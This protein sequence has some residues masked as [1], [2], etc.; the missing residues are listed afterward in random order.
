M[1]ISVVILAGGGTFHNSKE[2]DFPT[3]LIELDGVPLIQRIIKD[4][5]EF[6]SLKVIVVVNQNEVEKFHIE[7]TLHIIDPNIVVVG[8]TPTATGGAASSALLALQKVDPHS[9]VLFLNGNE[10]LDVDYK[11]L[12]DNFRAEE[13]DAGIVGFDSV[14]PRYS[15]AR[16]DNANRVIEVSEKDPI[17][18]NALAGFFWFSKAEDIEG[19]IKSMILKGNSVNG[20]FYL[21]PAIN[22]IL[23]EDGDVRLVKIDGTNY[24]PLKSE[25]HLSEYSRQIERRKI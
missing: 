13:I 16:I 25:W 9:E 11:L 3:S 4:L 19:A 17:S 24:H 12:V 15:F 21:A 14:H 7:K 23:L 2:A 8:V 6:S 18:R 5:S 20:T 10:K 22:E 1:S